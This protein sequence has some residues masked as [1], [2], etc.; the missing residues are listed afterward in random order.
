MSNGCGGTAAD[1]ELFV[2]PAVRQRERAKRSSWRG[3]NVMGWR[4]LTDWR[5]RRAGTWQ[6]IESIE[7]W[8]VRGAASPHEQLLPNIAARFVEE[9]MQIDRHYTMCCS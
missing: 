1:E 6:P 8:S 7:Y 5:R 9:G 4:S 2:Q 3:I